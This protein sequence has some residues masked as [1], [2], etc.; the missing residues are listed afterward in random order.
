MAQTLSDRGLRCQG[1]TFAH[2][3]ASEPVLRSV[4]LEVRPGELVA[5]LG[6]NGSGKTT[7]CLLLAGLIEADEG[8]VTLDGRAPNDWRIED[9]QMVQQSASDQIVAAEVGED[10]GFGVRNAGQGE[11]V[12]ARRVGEVLQRV[13]LADRADDAVE[14]LSGGETERLALGGAMAV[15]PAYLLADEPTAHL[16]P[17]AS[18]QVC[19]HLRDHAGSG[20]GVLM[21]TH[22]AEEAFFADR[23]VVLSQGQVVHQGPPTEVLYETDRLRAWDLAIPP[24]VTLVSELRALGVPVSGDPPSLAAL[25]ET[26]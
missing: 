18:G 20:A 26:L 21:V 3:D 11:D 5:L 4:T 1:V 16:D 22:R 13:G 9:L 10:A 25:L 15:A 24:L 19:A 2:P 17:V 12:V 7:L 8:L 14:H 6:G 23:V